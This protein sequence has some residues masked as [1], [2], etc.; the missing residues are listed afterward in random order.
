M[1]ER[2]EQISRLLAGALVFVAIAALFSMMLVTWVD[3]IGGKLFTW[4]VPGLTDIVTS[5]QLIVIVS[6]I[7]VTE[8]RG[9][10]VRVLFF[11]QKLP[12]RMQR[13]FAGLAAAVMVVFFALAAWQGYEYGQSLFLAGETTSTILIPLWPLAFWL[14]LCCFAAGL[15]FLAQLLRSITRGAE[16]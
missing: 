2:T 15:V 13:G 8:V 16:K 7:A 4:P 11:V 10:H 9:M 5:L 1:I 14:V 12:K 6:A 3:V